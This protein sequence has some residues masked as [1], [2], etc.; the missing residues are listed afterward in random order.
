MLPYHKL[1]LT[2]VG[3]KALSRMQQHICHEI[4]WMNVCMNAICAWPRLC[5]L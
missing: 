2:K 3:H 4:A 1:L 5:V